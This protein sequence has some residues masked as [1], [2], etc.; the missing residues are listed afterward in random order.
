M[1][2]A[3]TRPE[4]QQLLTVCG[5]S[6]HEPAGAHEALSG[7]GSARGLG[8]GLCDG[9]VAARTRTDIYKAG[10]ALNGIEQRSLSMFNV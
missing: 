7:N 8:G 3:T 6:A 10:N 9:G 4:N 1:S 5:S 2:A